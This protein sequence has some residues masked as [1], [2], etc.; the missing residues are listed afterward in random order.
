MDT[1]VLIHG[2]HLQA[3]E[4]ENIVWGN[5]KGGTLGRAPRGIQLAIC[6][7][8][9][10]IFWGTGASEKDG[11]KEAQFAF[12]YA[13]VHGCE[14]S[15]FSG[16]DPYEIESILRGISFIDTATQNTSQEIEC[17]AEV[18]HERGITRLILVSSPTHIPRCL[19]EAEKFRWAGKLHGIKIFA[20]ASDTCY[21]GSVPGDVLIVE[22]PHRGDRPEVP[23]HLTLR[24]AMKIGRGS[25]ASEFN[26]ALKKFMEPWLTS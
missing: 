14:L 18:C 24:Q 19:S 20:T 17:A 3:K 5:P 2:C 15:E 16:Y 11:M 21:A 25:H 6:E 10:L 23:I 8:A 22:P 4:W 13:V 12:N 7:K 9:E 1:G 26:E